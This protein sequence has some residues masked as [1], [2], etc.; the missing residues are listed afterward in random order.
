MVVGVR[1]RTGRGRVPRHTG[2]SLGHAGRHVLRA[3]RRRRR[4]YVFLTAAGRADPRAELAPG[5]TPLGGYK[6]F[7][8]FTFLPSASVN[9]PKRMNNRSASVQ[10]PSPPRV[11]SWST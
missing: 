2:R 1:P 7:Q 8:V 3:D 10:M 5:A 4:P 6:P 9:S 11:K